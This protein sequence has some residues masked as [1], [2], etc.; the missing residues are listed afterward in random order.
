MDERSSIYLESGVWNPGDTGSAPGAVLR[1]TSELYYEE[2]R[3][4]Y[5]KT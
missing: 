4:V 5:G 3:Q 1:E 2:V